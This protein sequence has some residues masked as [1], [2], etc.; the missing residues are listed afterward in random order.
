MLHK[1][2]VLFK[3]HV[4]LKQQLL[5]KQHVLRNL[6]YVGRND[7]NSVLW[8]VQILLALAFLIAGLMKLTLPIPKLAE[9]MG[10][11]NDFAPTTVRAI[12]LVEVLGAIGVVLPAL[13]GVLPW[14][15]PVA[16]AGLIL[17]M[18][19]ATATHIRRNEFPKIGTNVVLLLMAAFIV[20]GRFVAVPLG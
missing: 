9:R 1:R 16:A 8:I 19:G 5:H 7:M 17:V 6:L 18:I 3:P 4:L 14:L 10:F 15:T 13:T 12:G 20:Y 2:H 11:V